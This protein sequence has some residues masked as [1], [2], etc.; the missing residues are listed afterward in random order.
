MAKA[1]IPLAALRRYLVAQPC[2]CFKSLMDIGWQL[3]PEE[4]QPATRA[5]CTL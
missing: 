4:I 2:S 1:E 3:L 5:S